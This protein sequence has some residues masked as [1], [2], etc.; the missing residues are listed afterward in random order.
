MADSISPHIIQYYDDE[1]ILAIIAESP[2]ITAQFNEP[3]IISAQVCVVL[4]QVRRY[5]D[6]VTDQYD[7]D[8]FIKHAVVTDLGRYE[9]Y[10]VTDLVRRSVDI[11]PLLM[12]VSRITGVNIVEVAE[13]IKKQLIFLQKVENRDMPMAPAQIVNSR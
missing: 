5:P 8:V 6:Y 9:L 4:P 2:G 3:D 10:R 11:A 1:E 13:Q 7:L 12:A